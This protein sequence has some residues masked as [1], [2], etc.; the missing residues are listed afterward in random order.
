MDLGS[1]FLI[2]ALALLVAIYI[3]QPLLRYS[4]K[5]KLVIEVNS[6]K[7]PE[8]ERSVLLAEHD[9]LLTALQELDFDNTL[10]KIP[11]EDYPIQRMELLQAGADTLRKLDDFEP[12][13]DSKKSSAE[14]R[15]EAA[16]AARR[17]DARKR[18]GG[19]AEL[20]ELDLAINARRREKE[21]KS[22]G[23]CPKCGTAV[24]KS[25]DF[26]SRCGATLK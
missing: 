16:V 1:I 19:K 20:D 9:R 4:K 24:Q 8:H 17:A 15:I 22:A 5:E 12:T 14:D 10:G 2:I 7:D 23:F 6:V 11:V 18:T 3:A 13:N 21:E 25:D 26:C